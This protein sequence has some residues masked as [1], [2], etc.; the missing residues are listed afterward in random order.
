MTLAPTM[1]F[2]AEKDAGGRPAPKTKSQPSAAVVIRT[3]GA[4]EDSGQSLF[5]LKKWLSS[6]LFGHVTLVD[7]ST[8]SINSTSM[9]SLFIRRIFTAPFVN[10]CHAFIYSSEVSR[11]SFLN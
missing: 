6:R 11:A 3:R 4:T 2:V 8:H 1:S 7:S 5:S 10:L 9:R